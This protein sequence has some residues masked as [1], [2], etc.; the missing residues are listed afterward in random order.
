M[1]EDEGDVEQPGQPAGAEQLK[2]LPWSGGCFQIAD[3]D[4]HRH[5]SV[6]FHIP[7][8]R[9]FVRSLVASSFAYRLSLSDL[10]KDLYV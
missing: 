3:Y 7:L 6:S 5:S 2:Q 8:H 9:L 10:L 1:E 4:V